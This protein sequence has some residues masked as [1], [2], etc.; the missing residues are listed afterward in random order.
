M[1]LNIRK[2]AKQAGFQGEALDTIVAIV[3]AES[4][5]NP[6][7]HNNNA[8]TG[9]NSYGLAQIN[10]LGGMG[11]ERR[12]RYGLSSNEDLFDPL[13]NLRVAYQLSNGGKNFSPWTTYTS[14][15]YRK[16]LGNQG[17]NIRVAER[18]AAA[19]SSSGGGLGAAQGDPFGNFVPNGP[20]GIGAATAPGTGASVAL[21]GDEDEDLE[22]PEMT[23]QIYDG[24]FKPVKPA[25]SYGPEARG[26][27]MRQE[28][29]TAVGGKRGE[30]VR[31]AK[32]FVGTPYV[33]GGTDP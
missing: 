12:D 10:M 4:G 33:W 23:A 6:R 2:V 21:A 15:A 32:S 3:Q 24:I 1:P 13:T 18:Q 31:L 25:P 8:N 20:L 29:I 19:R 26:P 28:D 9:D 7:A 16:F 27:A 14:G 22:L 11:P 30:L 17:A 5:G